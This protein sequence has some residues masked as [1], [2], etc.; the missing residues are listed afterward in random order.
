[1]NQAIKDLY[2]RGSEIETI[3]GKCRSLPRVRVRLLTVPDSN[4][5]LENRFKT[6]SLYRLI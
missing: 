4:E 3:A 2:T 1:M 5:K 6:G